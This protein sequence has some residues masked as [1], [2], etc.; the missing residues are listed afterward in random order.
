MTARATVR[1]R[2]LAFGAMVAVLILGGALALVRTDRGEAA[3]PVPSAPVRTAAAPTPTATGARPAAQVR[4]AW[5]AWITGSL[6]TGM[7]DLAAST[8][9]LGTTVVVAGDTRWMTSSHAAD[10]SV[11]DRPTPPFEIPIDAFSVD[12]AAYGP[13][14]SSDV[15]AEV[16]SALRSGEAVLGASS[17][18]LRDL[19]VGGS[20]TFGSRTIRVGAVVPDPDA[21]W[22]EMLVS[23]AI[24]RSLGIVDDRYLLA[25]P[26]GRMTLQ[27]FGGIMR[28]LIPGTA[29]RMLPPGGSTYMRIASGVNP[30]VVMKD[31]FGEFAAYPQSADPAYLTVDPA[32]YEAHI[33]TR[34]VPI[35]GPVTCNRRLFP[36]LIGALTDVQTAGLGNELHVYSGCYAARTVA[37]SPTAPPSQHAYGA[38][39][40]I[41]A[42]ENPYGAQPTM[43]PRI[44][45]I[46][47]RWGFLWGGTFL[48]PDG[49]HFE[50][51]AAPHAGVSG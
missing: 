48:T 34:S 25:Q 9:S 51:G 44:V 6:P 43:D 49:M 45:R 26:A 41:N 39:I 11:V 38:A 35:L 7:P 46:F 12:P 13:F 28:R 32:W 33:V 5:L 8:P 3:H 30:P 47:R 4:D 15:R 14:V 36:M 24:G 21:G 18:K 2:R 23:R 19:D 27:R 31:V 42:P 10:G 22:S 50:Y 40:D 17:A 37:R 1:R 20:M 16:T 29:I